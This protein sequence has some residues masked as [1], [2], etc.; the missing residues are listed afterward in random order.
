MTQCAYKYLFGV[1]GTGIH[2]FRFLDTAIV[3]YLGTI[4]LA[5]IVTKLTKVPLV[6]TTI[7]MFLLGIILHLFV[8]LHTGTEAWF[9]A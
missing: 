9:F 5:M 4:L 2:R 6:I 8:C 1:P 3:D 7:G